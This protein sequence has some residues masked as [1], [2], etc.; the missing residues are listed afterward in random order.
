VNAVMTDMHM[1]ITRHEQ[2]ALHL[3]GVDALG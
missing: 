1:P 3:I 2:S